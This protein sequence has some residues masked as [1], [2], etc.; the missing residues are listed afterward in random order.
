MRP[1]LLLLAL[2]LAAALRAETVTYVITDDSTISFTGHKD[3]PVLGKGSKE[4]EFLTYEG[5]LTL[6]GGDPATLVLKGSVDMASL[7]TDSDRFTEA[8]SSDS[9]FGSNHHG[10]ATFASTAVKKT[11]SGLEVTGDLTIKGK[12]MPITFP[13]QLEVKGDTVTLQASFK[14]NRQNWNIQY[15]G[16][17]LKDMYI[18]NDAD[19]R[20]NLVAKKKA[21]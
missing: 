8:L 20:W 16:A 18:L 10:E 2:L 11:P 3:V 21:G 5:T 17:F 19:V 6:T 9:F 14:I 15:K 1:L 13:A 12:A 4:G 7:S